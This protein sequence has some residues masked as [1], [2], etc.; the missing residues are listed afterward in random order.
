MYK[1]EIIIV[2]TSWTFGGWEF[3]RQN[4]SSGLGH[5]L[6]HSTHSTLRSYYL[7]PW[8]ISEAAWL[9]FK[10]REANFFAE[11]KR[12]HLCLP[13]SIRPQNNI[14][15]LLDLLHIPVANSNG[16]RKS[17]STT[18]TQDADCC[19]KAPRG[20]SPPGVGVGGRNPPWTPP[21]QHILP[22]PGW[23]YSLWTVI[24]H[25]PKHC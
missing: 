9:V 13:A 17:S 21:P 25:V 5:R 24:T 4:T 20:K 18:P 6:I 8:C 2:P 7:G 19:E 12:T 22:N 11:K 10:R 16:M 14:E 23:N 3:L 15:E 1:M